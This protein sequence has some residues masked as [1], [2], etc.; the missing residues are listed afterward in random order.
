MKLKVYGVAHI[1]FFFF[2]LINCTLVIRLSKQATYIGGTTI[3]AVSNIT[4]PIFFH[5]LASFAAETPSWR[6]G[7]FS[8]SSALSRGKLCNLL[9]AI[10]LC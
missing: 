9:L 5:N 3:L 2:R 8:I 4:D 1:F 7:V 10:S 6:D